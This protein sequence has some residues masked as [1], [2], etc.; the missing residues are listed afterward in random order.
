MKR[1]IAVLLTLIMLFSFAVTSSALATEAVVAAT[2]AAIIAQIVEDVDDQR[3]RFWD[4]L[5]EQYEAKEIDSNTFMG[6]EVNAAVGEYTLVSRY[7]GQDSDYLGNGFYINVPAEFSGV[8]RE[9]IVRDDYG[10]YHFSNFYGSTV[11]DLVTLYLNG[12]VAT[13]L[14][15]YSSLEAYDIFVY[16]FA[17]YAAYTEIINLLSGIAE[18]MGVVEG[19]SGGSVDIDTSEMEDSLSS[20][21]S[22][23]SQ[24]LT[25]LSALNQNVIDTE[26]YAKAIS[27]ALGGVAVDVADIESELVSIGSQLSTISTK[28][29][30]LQDSLDELAADNEEI[31]GY[32]EDIEY[33]VLVCTER[34]LYLHE[35]IYAVNNSITETN[36]ILTTIKD[37]VDGIQS[38]VI[39]KLDEL[40]SAVK[41]IGSVS[42]GDS[43]G[44]DGSS[45][46]SD[47]IG[48]FFGV[49]FEALKLL[50]NLVFN[51][52][53]SVFGLVARFT[54]FISTFWGD[55][56][57]ADILAILLIIPPLSFI[58][59]V[60]KFVR[61]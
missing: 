1:F 33:Y 18:N 42:G 5:K 3:D 27:E 48:G 53:S 19:G 40:I 50:L 24:V 51:L 10:T 46:V 11:Y 37:K 20:I 8:A 34:L 21:D 43:S 14:C 47:L 23:L 29:D 58:L 32:V 30:G 7:Q 35:A 44:S 38:A 25:Y 28:F 6:L 17:T 39:G 16:D 57:P 36:N 22:S 41:R 12:T 56:I 60:V 2:A 52:L 61:G 31:K 59:G 49:V 15:H 4:W 13:F 26:N 45:F 9:C 54:E 55:F